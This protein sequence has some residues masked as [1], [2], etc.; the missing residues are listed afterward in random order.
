MT[1]TPKREDNID[2]YEYFGEPVFEY[3]LGQAI[4]DGVLN[5]VEPVTGRVRVNI[6]SI[7]DVYEWRHPLPREQK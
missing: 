6:G 1:A 5:E 4:E 3:S 7:I 2:V